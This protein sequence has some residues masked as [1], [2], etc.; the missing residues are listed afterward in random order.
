MTEHSLLQ[1]I[2]SP[3]DRETTWSRWLAERMGGIAE[4]RIDGVRVDILTSSLA[5]EVEWV[6][7]LYEAFAQASLY[8]ALTNRQPAVILLLRGKDTEEVY[9]QRANMIS[10]K[11]NIP[12]FTWNTIQPEKAKLNES[13]GER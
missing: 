2:P 8:G 5:I 12:V 10:G 11:L 4:Y 13:E 3:T 1:R 7:K 9:L 6:K